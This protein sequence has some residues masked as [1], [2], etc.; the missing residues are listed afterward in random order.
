MVLTDM[1]TESGKAWQ[2]CPRDVLRKFSKILEDEFGLVM[3]V[4]IEVEFYLFKSVLKDGKE[5]WATIDRT[6]YCSTTAIDVASLVLQEIVASLHSF[7]ILVEQVSF[8]F[9]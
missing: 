6:S 3:N 9:L 7:N 4:G 2:Y 1:L 5:T 8:Q